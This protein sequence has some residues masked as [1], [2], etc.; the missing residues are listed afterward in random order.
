MI[1]IMRLLDSMLNDYCYSQEEIETCFEELEIGVLDAQSFLN[2]YFGM[3][4]NES[5]LSRFKKSLPKWRSALAVVQLKNE[6]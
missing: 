4:L 2:D 1:I 3:D 6:N 5:Q